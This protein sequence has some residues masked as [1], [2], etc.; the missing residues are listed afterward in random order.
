MDTALHRSK[1]LLKTAYRLADGETNMQRRGASD[2]RSDDYD[3]IIVA[4]ERLRQAWDEKIPVWQAVI[5]VSNEVIANMSSNDDIITPVLKCDFSEEEKQRFVVSV[6]QASRST[7]L[8]ILERIGNPEATTLANELRTFQQDERG[9]Y[10]LCDMA[11]RILHF[12]R[13]NKDVIQSAISSLSFDDIFTIIRS[14]VYEEFRVPELTC[15]CIIQNAKHVNTD[16]FQS[17]LQVLKTCATILRTY[18]LEYKSYAG[19]KVTV[20]REVIKNMTMI[21][22]RTLQDAPTSQLVPSAVQ[23]TPTAL[24][25]IT[26]TVSPILRTPALN[27]SLTPDVSAA[28]V[29]TEDPT[30]SPPVDSVN[31]ASV[32]SE[33]GAQPVDLEP[34]APIPEPEPVELAKSVAPVSKLKPDIARKVESVK[35]VTPRAVV[36]TVELQHSTGPHPTQDQLQAI[37]KQEQSHAHTEATHAHTAHSELHPTHTQ[38][39]TIQAH[40]H[41]EA[42][43]A[44]HVHSTHTELRRAEKAICRETTARRLLRH[45]NPL[46]KK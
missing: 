7:C 24:G 31:D 29:A 46:A 32:T 9:M 30:F 22:S 13:N 20:L 27:G 37:S 16:S 18:P 42:T 28:T 3:A 23:S 35:P 43:H 45:Y 19:D 2:I 39:H 26:D 33:S 5:Q 34:V 38:S 41:T 14:K 4:I 44:R 12:V 8:R 21:L 11:I 15:E 25:P 36:A 1:L 10:T 17:K 40:A 6:I